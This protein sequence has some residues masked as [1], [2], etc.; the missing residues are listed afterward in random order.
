MQQHGNLVMSRTQVAIIGAGP[1]GL[2]LSQLLYLHGIANVVVERRSREHVLGRIRAGVLEQ[3]TVDLLLEAKLGDRMRKERIVHE[4]FSLAFAARSLR[5][6]LRGLAGGSVSVYGQTEV[7]KDL[8]EAREA[9]NA[10]LLFEATEVSVEGFDRNQPTVRYRHGGQLHEL[11]CDFV[12]GCDGY[13]GVSRKSV[14]A[15]AMQIFERVYPFG[16]LGVLAEV[17]PVGEELTYSNS[18]RGFALCSMRSLTRS[19]YY[20]QCG[21]DEKVIAFEECSVTK[22]K[23]DPQVGGMT[24][25]KLTVQTLMNEHGKSLFDFADSS[26]PVVIK[27]GKLEVVKDDEPE[28]PLGD[29]EEDPAQQGMSLDESV[30]KDGTTKP[31]KKKRDR[32]KEYAARKAK[33]S[34][35]SE[36]NRAT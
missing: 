36:E 25:V 14:P 23:I 21:L 33:R 28:L 16:W 12:A 5:V 11:Q 9:A 22:I 8:V 34:N 13:H 29:G 10:G 17:P 19:R 31:A 1:S 18:T 30:A 35:G 32:S 27:L 6:D 7:T 2:L 20:I 24:N 3:G 4:G 15:G 26:Q